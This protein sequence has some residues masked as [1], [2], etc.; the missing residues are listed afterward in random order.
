MKLYLK[1]D[2]SSENSRFLVLDEL[3]RESF[4]VLSSGKSLEKLVITTADGMVVTKINRLPLPMFFAYSITANGRNIRF[5]LNPAKNAR[6]CYYYGVSWHIRGDVF[7]KSFDILD[8][9]N[10]V[11]AVHSRC[12]GVCDGYELNI[13]S[14]ENLQLCL[15]SAVCVNTVALCDNTA[16]KFTEAYKWINYLKY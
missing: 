6:N 3:C 11:L 15:A 5:I 8:V 4:Y 7:T 14:E 2:L 1:R 13:Y 10:S 12:F 9:D 16:I